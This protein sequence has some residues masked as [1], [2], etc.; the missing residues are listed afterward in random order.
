MASNPGNATIRISAAPASRSA[1]SAQ[2]VS[3]HSNPD[4]KTSVRKRSAALPCGMRS[5][6]D[7]VHRIV[8]LLACIGNEEIEC[9]RIDHGTAASGFLRRNAH[10]Q[11]THRHLHLLTGAGTRY[12]RNLIDFVRYM[13]RGVILAQRGS[14]L[15][16]ERRVEHNPVA[17]LDEQRHEKSAIGQIEID[18]ERILNFAQTRERAV[19]LGSA[20]AHTIAIQRGIRP[21][22]HVAA[23][24]GVDAKTTP[25]PPDIREIRK[26][27]FGGA[28]SIVIPKAQR[29]RR[30]RFGDHEFA[31]FADNALSVLIKGLYRYSQAG[32]LNFTRAH[33]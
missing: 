1:T 20:D 3:S 8:V 4:R 26:V 18:D 33:R 19:D 2:I 10:Q 16:L 23:A 13:T 6:I 28:L 24:I 32:R 11:S 15:L 22:E 9:R 29:H 30:H 5:F 31:D 25:L 21:T 17:Q 7:R 14:Y 12:G 27:G